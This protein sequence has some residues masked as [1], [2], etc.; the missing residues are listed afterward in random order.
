MYTTVV[1]VVRT[2]LVVVAGGTEVVSGTH[3]GLGYQGQGDGVVDTVI[4]GYPKTLTMG[5]EG[6]GERGERYRGVRGRMVIVT[7][8]LV[9]TTCTYI[10]C[11]YREP[12]ECPMPCSVQYSR[13]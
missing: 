5:G 8:T 4:L 9:V 1:V 6:R 2:K 10:Q 3:E 12:T 7:E 11:L 13:D